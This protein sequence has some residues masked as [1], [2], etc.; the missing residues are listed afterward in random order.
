MLKVISEM[1]RPAFSMSADWNSMGGIIQ[2]VD[3]WI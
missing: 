3:I 2:F 1:K